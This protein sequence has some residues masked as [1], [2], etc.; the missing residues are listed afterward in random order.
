MADHIGV[1]QSEVVT[2]AAQ[3]EAI[4]DRVDAAASAACTVR[5]GADAYGKLCAMVPVMLNS[6]QDVLV[7]GIQ[8]TAESLRDTGTRLRAT[9]SDYDT[10]D[11]RRCDAFRRIGGRP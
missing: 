4:A 5:A 7:D 3:V 6:L 8:A 10:A 9:A 11:R 1:R 2:H